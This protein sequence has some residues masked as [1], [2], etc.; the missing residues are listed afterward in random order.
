MP[1]V[2]IDHYRAGFA[3]AYGT[4]PFHAFRKNLAAASPAEWDVQPSHWSRDEF[5]DQPEL[6]ICDIALHVGG[7]VRDVHRPRLRRGQARM[8]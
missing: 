2:L 1:R 7:G 6:S 8:G 3:A 4:D 5:G